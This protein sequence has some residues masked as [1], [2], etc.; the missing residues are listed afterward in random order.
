MKWTV[1]RVQ[2]DKASMLGYSSNNLQETGLLCK[3]IKL[4]LKKLIAIWM[5]M[6][7]LSVDKYA[8]IFTKQIWA[9]S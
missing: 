8:N 2:N 1:F 3:K 4:K 7:L 6:S 5:Q 9:S